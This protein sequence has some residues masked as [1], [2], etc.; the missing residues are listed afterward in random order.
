MKSKTKIEEQE[1]ETL[2]EYAKKI[3][4]NA[5][6]EKIENLTDEKFQ[7]LIIPLVE[8][9]FKEK[10]GPVIETSIKDRVDHHMLKIK[11]VVKETIKELFNS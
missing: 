6:I 10:I 3:I 5:I 4:G 11:D 1:V 7:E 8:K 2:D 9:E